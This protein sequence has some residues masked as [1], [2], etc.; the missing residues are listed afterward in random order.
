MLPQDL[1]SPRLLAPR[2]V[3]RSSSHFTRVVRLFA[4]ECDV[5]YEL[6]VV[7]DLLETNPAAYA[8]NPG[9]KLPNLVTSDGVVFGALNSCR[10]LARLGSN[11][12]DIV[13]P[14]HV[15]SLVAANAQELTLQAMASEVTLI[16]TTAEGAADSAYAAKL[17]SALIGMLGWL[18]AHVAQACAELPPRKLSY[19][20]AALFSL[21]GHLEFRD[22][23]SMGDYPRLQAFA[24]VWGQRQAAVLTPFRFD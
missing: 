1:I 10:T 5:P 8:G 20:E 21:V 13:W 18:D 22:V 3:G 4:H 12:A 15:R 2:I 16:L 19:F 17:R 23:V 6:Q 11:V 24:S 7:P 9:L 14:E